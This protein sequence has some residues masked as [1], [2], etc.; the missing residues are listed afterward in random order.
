LYVPV[1]KNKKP[2]TTAE[3]L[4]LTSSLVGM[5]AIIIGILNATK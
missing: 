4:G 2:L 3:I 5:G 1:R